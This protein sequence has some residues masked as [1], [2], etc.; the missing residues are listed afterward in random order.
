MA[1]CQKGPLNLLRWFSTLPLPFATG[2]HSSRQGS[3]YNFGGGI[4][5]LF[6]TPADYLSE[7][8]TL[9][10]MIAIFAVVAYGLFFLAVIALSE[11]RGRVLRADV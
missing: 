2:L 9:S 4:G 10:D 7:H 5:A 3:C 11:T 6:P 1:K 8:M